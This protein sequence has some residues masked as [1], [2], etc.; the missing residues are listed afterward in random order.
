MV[1]ERVQKILSQAGLGSRREMERWIEQ[2]LVLVNGVQ[3][4]LGDS[5]DENAKLTVKG[6][7]IANPLSSQMLTRV[8]LYHKPVG[9]I[10]SRQNPKYSKTV[11]D[12]LPRLRQQ[13]WIQVGRL[14][15]NTS[16]LLLFTN[17]GNLA[18]RLMHPSFGL[19]REYAVRVH[20][21]VQ[22]EHLAAL[23]K[24]VELEDGLAKFKRIVYKG[25]EGANAWYH[26]IL[27]EGKN[28]EVRRLW[29]SQGLEVSRLIRIRYGNTMLP[30]FLNR[31]DYYEL[32][33]KEV[34]LFLQEY[35]RS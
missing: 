3:I 17:D 31:G 13:R 32:S 1:K 18:N 29:Q 22:Q 14:D 7:T 24:G 21:Q 11:F 10:C 15:L 30:R 12:K 27:T 34:D 23:T 6:K 8:L 35:P 2:G 9:E 33:A 16:G 4:S 28:R 26:V 20:G 19:E 5:A 25:G